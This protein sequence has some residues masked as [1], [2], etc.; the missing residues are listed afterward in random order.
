[1]PGHGEGVGEDF[2]QL[3]RHGADAAGRYVPFEDDDEF[4]AADPGDD[5][6]AAAQLGGHGVGGE[7]EDFVAHR[8]A[9]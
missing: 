6:V 2:H 7:L 9:K 1:M 8:V 5:G 3:A 4:V